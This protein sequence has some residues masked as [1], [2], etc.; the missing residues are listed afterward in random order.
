MLRS[1]LIAALS[2]AALAAGF[3]AG[4]ATP[5]SAAADPSTITL[6]YNDDSGQYELSA[7]TI[8]A[9]VGDTFVFENDVVQEVKL[10]NGTGTISVGGTTCTGD[11]CTVSAD[12][13]AGDRAT[14][15]VD[16]LGT[17]TINYSSSKTVTITESPD[18]PTP[19][20]NPALVYPTLTLDANG[21]TCA[22]T[23]QFT[24]Y[25]GRNGTVLLPTGDACTRSNY[26]L[27]GWA[28]ASS[29][30]A[31][32]FGAGSS[33]PIGDESFTLYGVWIPNGV[34]VTYDAN[35]GSGDE[36]QSSGASTDIRTS[37]SVVPSGSAT[38]TSAPC[39]PPGMEFEGWALTGD[40]DVVT[41]PG[42]ALPDL[43]VSG[44]SLQLYAKWKV[45][46]G[47]AISADPAALTPGSS[48]TITV[49]AQRNGAPAANA[50]FTLKAS[51]DVTFGN[52]KTTATFTLFADGKAT[53]PVYSRSAGTGTIEAAY[54]DKT[55]TTTIV[56]SKSI[57]IIG[58]RGTVK[59]KR[60]IMVDGFTAGFAEGE[61]VVPW[62]RFPGQSSYSASSARPKID[63]AGEFYWRLETG[64][65]GK[66]IYVYF[67]NEEGTVKS[68]RIK[69]QA[70]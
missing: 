44:S 31:S 21:G 45:T 24:K 62:I 29:A 26:T 11:D 55:S 13:N 25:N 36:C 38:D 16:A 37:T 2:S 32:D 68:N 42:G 66:K 22:G 59:G 12:G 8:S 43:G 58:K 46:Y 50:E 14:V 15:R 5:A 53:I 39:T 57:T 18:S 30:S 34:Q 47:V 4:A 10:R 33:V 67:K 54:G 6:G 23:M 60:G 51:D 48:A 17:F 64:E 3:L 65:K 52:G 27:G 9:G 40:G 56:L 28:R 49:T 70:R 20:R 61:M 41:Q 7:S 19:P 63:A 35:V 1:R 69:I